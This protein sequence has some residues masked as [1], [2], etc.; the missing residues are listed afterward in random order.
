MDMVVDYLPSPSQRDPPLAI[1][2]CFTGL[3]DPHSVRSRRVRK[4][5]EKAAVLQV[6]PTTEGFP[7]PLDKRNPLCALAFKVVHDVHRDLVVWFR[8]YSGVLKPG[9]KVFNSVTARTEL[10]AKLFKI[11]AGMCVCVCV[12]VVV[13]L[14][15]CVV[16]WLCVCVGG[17]V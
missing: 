17:W 1:P 10:V 5:E 7:V 14:C 16:V 6:D 9:V 11:D 2:L 13:W 8:V 4:Q 12:C 15:V 3:S